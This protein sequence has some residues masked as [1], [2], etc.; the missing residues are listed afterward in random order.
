MLG[1]PESIGP[2]P[3]LKETFDWQPRWNITETIDRILEFEIIRKLDASSN[4][5]SECMNKQIKEYVKTL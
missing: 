4:E 3:K 2:V 5:L 1:R